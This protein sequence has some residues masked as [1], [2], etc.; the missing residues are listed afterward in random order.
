MLILQNEVNMIDYIIDKAYEK[1]MTIILNPSP[2]DED[3]AKCDLSKVSIFVLNEIEAM[4]IYGEEVQPK[5]FLKFMNE[6][7]PNSQVVLTLG[8]EG[9]YYS[10]NGKTIFQPIFKVKAVDTTAAGDTY[11]GYFIKSIV[12]GYDMEKAMEIAALASSIT[13]R[14]H[15]AVASIPYFEDVIDDYK[16]KT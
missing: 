9:S 11:T 1:F 2:F 8:T 16:K 15:G 14:K 3:V 10:Y 13:V 5:V 12:E 7:Y 6:K 4:Q